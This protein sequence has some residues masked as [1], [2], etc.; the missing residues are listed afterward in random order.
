MSGDRDIFLAEAVE[1]PTK[2]GRYRNLSKLAG[3]MVSPIVLGAASIGDKWHRIGLGAMDKESSFKLLDA[4]YGMGGNFI[5]TANGTRSGLHLSTRNDHL[6][7]H[8]SSEE[9]LGEWMATRGVRDQ[10]VIATKYSIDSQLGNKDIPPHAHINFAGN[11]AKSLY[12]SV[13]DS[14]KRLRTEY[15]DI[16]FVHWWG[17]DTP[18]QEVMSHLHD[19][20]AAK[21]VLYLGVSDTPAWVVSQANQW[22]LDHG[23][24]PF[25]VYQGAW[26]V[27]DR[28]FERE[29]IPMAREWGMALMPWEVLAAGRIRSDA[30]ERRRKESGEGGRDV[31]FTGWERNEHEKQ[32]CAALEKV[33]KETGVNSV[34][35]VAIAY[36]MQKTTYVFP[37]VG[38]RKIEH[39]KENIKALDIRLTPDQISYIES[40]N[41]FEPG[42]P[43]SFIGNGLSEN[44]FM[45]ATAK[46]D[47]VKPAEPIRVA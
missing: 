36:L 15:I 28:S 14:L 2:L 6:L 7:Q 44:L 33:G 8:G 42:F 29:I 13:R 32:V 10:M 18:I 9:F 40:V 43:H 26:N 5:D 21:K 17:Y 19:L 37:I 11:N 39:L 30:D 46:I 1:P 25:V 34:T 41:S 31:F 4:Y 35:A 47:R 45:N 23:K 3:V 24:T 38:G 20:V 12:I 22:A 27:M 16:L